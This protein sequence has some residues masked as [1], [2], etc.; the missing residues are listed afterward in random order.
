MKRINISILL[1]FAT[2]L[3]SV[4]AL[5][6]LPTEVTSIN[7]D[8]G[9]I[10]VLCNTTVTVVFSVDMDGPTI[11]TNNFYLKLG[12][13]GSKISSTV[14]YNSSTRT[15]ILTPSTNLQPNR[16]YR[17]YL[18]RNIR[19]DAGLGINGGTTY[20][21]YDFTTTTDNIPPVVT[22]KSPD[23]SA[24]GI[25]RTATIMAT[26]TENID[27]ATLTSSNFYV[28]DGATNIGGSISYDSATYTVTFTPSPALSYYTTYTV[29]ITTGVRDVIGNQMAADEVWTFTTMAN[30]T[31][32][33]Y[34][35]ELSPAD[36]APSVT[37][38]ATINAVFSEAIAPA[39][40][41]T[42][43]FY[44]DH[45]ITG[46]VG[47]NAAT[48]T[49]TFTPDPP[50]L[51]NNTVYTATITTGVTDLA[52]NHMSQT[53]TWSFT[54]MGTYT[55]NNVPLNNYCQTPPFVT[56]G[57]SALK[58]NVM[59]IVDN[60]ISMWEFA[61]KTSGKGTFGF[62][63]S[64]NSGASYY[65]YF[66]AEKMYSYAT[67]EGGYFYPD[68]TKTLNKTKFN[69]TDGYS[70][71]MLNWLV[72][73]RGDVVKKVLVGGKTQPRS[74]NVANYV[75]PLT[76]PNMDFWKQYGS[77]YFEVDD[78]LYVCSSSSCNTH[79]DSFNLKIYIGNDEPDDGLIIKM[80]D[81][82][83][84]G[85]MF[86]NDG[87]KFEDRVN[88]VKDG[89]EVSVNIGS[90]GTN[91]YTQVEEMVPATYTPLA[92]TLYESTRYFQA[93]EKA[94]NGGTYNGIDPLTASCMK[95]FVLIIT[96]GES[97]KDQ[98]L[99]GTAFTAGNGT[100][101][102]TLNG[103]DI[104]DYMDKIDA[105]EGTS[106]L[107]KITGTAG[108]TTLYNVAPN[109]LKGSWYL[110]GVALFAHTTDLRSATMGK[111]NLAGMQNLG[112]Y[113]VFAFDDSARARYLLK[114]TSKYGGFD[115]SNMTSSS[116]PDSV[117]NWGK[118]DN[119]GI[120]DLEH[121]T[122]NTYFEAQDGDALKIAVEKALNDILS[123]VSSGTSASIVNNR[124]ESGANLFQAIFYPRTT[125]GSKELYWIGEMQNM[126]YYLDPL[127]STSSIREDTDYDRK[128]DLRADYKVTVDYD[129]TQNKTVANWYQDTTGTG[130]FTKVSTG[131]PDNIHALWRAGG[132]LHYR[133]DTTRTIKTVL[134][135]GNTSYLDDSVTPVSNATS[136]LT[137]FTT[138]YSNSISNYL[139]VSDTT[140]GNKLIN[141]IRGLDYLNDP[142]YR[143]RTTTITY[144]N[145]A[146]SPLN[147]TVTGVWKLGDIVS[148][149]PQAQ[150]S[151]QLQAF[152]TSYKDTSYSL[153]YGSPDYLSRNMVYTAANDGML[154]A[155]RS[156]R[157]SRLG[158][159][160]SHP[161]RIA[162]I[163]NPDNALNIGDEEWAFIPKN[164]LP[165]LKYLSD[166]LYNHLYYVN[167]TVM[168]LDAS[169]N[170][171]GNA[172][173]CT[174]Q[175]EYWKCEKKTTFSNSKVCS[176]DFSTPCSTN[177]NC[178]TGNTCM[179]LLDQDLTSWRTVL[180]GGMGL[181]GAS[182]DYA[183]YCNKDDGTTPTSSAQE[184]RFDCVKSPIAGTGLSSF[185]ALDVTNPQSP[186]FMWEFSDAIL[187][188][189]DKG[190][191]FTT[192]G[193]SLVRISARSPATEDHGTP[194]LSK[195]GRWFA[196]FATGPSGPIDT[197]NHQFK[198]RS[199]NRLKVYVVDLHPDLSS[200]WVK[201]TNYWVLDSGIDNAFAGDLTDG[202][203]D[204]DR[205]NPSSNS[206]YSDDVVY[207]GYTKQSGTDWT[208]GGVLR[209]LTNDSLNP[210][211]WTLSTLIDSIGPVTS[212]P[213]KLQDRKSGNLWLFFGTGRYFWKDKD[214]QDDPTNY[215]HLFGIKEPCYS[216]ANR[217]NSGFLGNTPQG[218]TAT[219]PTPLG[220]SDLANQSTSLNSMTGKSGW[221]IQLD[222]QGNYAIGA[223]MNVAEYDAE[224]VVTN[225]MAAFNGVVTFTTFK[226]T[227][228]LCGYG[229]ATLVW[230][231]DYL[232]G[233]VPPAST[234]KGKLL[235][236][237]SGGEFV[238]YDL[239]TATKSGGDSTQQTR[240]DR[241]IRASL[242]G[243]GR[244]GDRAGSLQS[245]SRPIRQILH[246]MEK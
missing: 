132:L 207:I 130:S 35:T 12:G 25:A 175:A 140:T 168:L 128:L 190:L 94:Y 150:T 240:D 165:Y 44:L 18:S 148:S 170:R 160:A 237:L 149:T 206:Y 50:G 38:N 71:N 145:S 37:L 74:I 95:N 245:M 188:A 197:T 246:I 138:A 112:I 85:I 78:K 6:A 212:S 89:G 180:I 159:D 152:D 213:T 99:P 98:N 32:P 179:A 119:T 42:S 52:T 162:Q 228:D 108:T 192:S 200:G 66:N 86:F 60:S 65:G 111:S 36:T 87:Y 135:S 61:Y 51:A 126:W 201:N 84:F 16:S 211:D 77:Q 81:R 67:N 210:A 3:F 24:P 239:A 90:T 229:G 101:V 106:S 28:S 218:C 243:F 22:L 62:D 184:T 199:D 107:S 103:F 4:N 226:P 96:D 131:S 14:T 209:L 118:C 88:S 225:T 154:H 114:L 241:R 121:C 80:R 146:P 59:L 236:Q 93:V 133:S 227:N 183:G 73:R 9:A 43:S 13:S 19:T 125:L 139:N 23:N 69:A 163:T 5:A 7:P 232:N 208:D 124:G 11:N 91:V 144:S 231:V 181:G 136:G 194:D 120:V 1:L 72:M 222:P 29:T 41:T 8:D 113:T 100:V 141:Y 45:G 31:T 198:G 204:V 116:L 17:I 189:A 82:I 123:K 202:V 196:V 76:S 46:T 33:P 47:F 182:R 177:A 20:S 173:A 68:S 26:F 134:G 70:G 219:E 48:N 30:D 169:I 21:D 142:N 220:F 161:Y 242:A 143:A 157:V 215:R 151:K 110:P 233:W 39:T 238:T 203:I 97:T 54:T 234:M 191:G 104:E 166:P 221:Y 230:F 193:P 224:R 205:W 15:A 49:A 109:N 158:Y 117:G 217:M 147:S 195:N 122:P 64:Y 178:G 115:D 57:S 63:Q 185:F 155:F 186:K 79:T 216:A 244:S 176:N 53:K 10:N 56:S 40:L 92:E 187:P 105:T 75:Y 174:G 164:A 34:V 137:S 58:P 214:G 127:L 167:N 129:T 172:T 235:V 156:G 83:N 27:S 171:P 153:F 2:L 223:Q 55:V 102:T